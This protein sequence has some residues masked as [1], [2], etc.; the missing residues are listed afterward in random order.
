MK[1]SF[2][3]GLV[4]YQS[5][6]LSKS[7][8]SVYLLTTNKPMVYSVSYGNAE[9]LITEPTSQGQILAW[10]NTPTSG[11]SWLYI[12]INKNTAARTF[13]FTTVEP[14]ASAS[15]PF[16]P[17]SSIPVDQHWFDT[18]AKKMKV[19]DGVRWTEYIRVF[20]GKITN[21]TVISPFPTGSQV[22]IVGEFVSGKLLFD[23]F[24]KVLKKADKTFFTSEDKWFVDA[25]NVQAG[26]LENDIT[27]ALANES[28]PEFHVVKYT[29]FGRV[30]LADYVDTE[31]CAM[32]MAMESGTYDEIVSVVFQGSIT[33]PNWNWP[34]VNA[35]LWVGTGGT[36]VLE[37]PHTNNALLPPQVPVA[38][39]VSPTTVIF[40]QGL[41]GVGPEGPRGPAGADVGP[42]TQ[43][44]LGFVKI[45][46]DATDPENPIAVE[47][48]DP[49]LY[50]SRFPL[51]HSHTA[52][53]ISTTA[54]GL[55]SGSN[56]QVNLQELENRKF[57]TTGGTLSGPLYLSDT[58]VTPNQA[59]TKQYVD[60]IAVGLH[61]I[62]PVCAIN[63]ISD[64]QVSPPPVPSFGD[65]YIIPT[66]ALGEWTG[67]DYHA[68][69]WD[70]AAWEDMGVWQTELGSVNRRIGVSIDSPTIASGTFAGRDNSVAIWD[71]A[72][73]VWSFYIPVDSDAFYVCNDFSLYKHQQFIYDGVRDLWVVFG[74][75]QSLTPGNQLVL[76]GN[77]LDVVEGSGSDLDADMVDGLHASAFALVDHNHDALYV[78]VDGDT[79]TGPITFN[80]G[81][82]LIVSG[83][84][85]FQ[86][87]ITVSSGNINVQTG[88]VV[89]EHD[90]T[91]NLEVATKHYVD[92]QDQSVVDYANN[93]FALKTHTHNIP[94]DFNFFASGR[95]DSVDTTI[96]LVLSPREVVIPGDLSNSYA[97]AGVVPT[98]NT[99][100]KIDKNGTQV[101]TVVFV[102]GSHTGT[103]SSSTG[104]EVIQVLAGD[105][106]SI[107]TTNTID[108]TLADVAISIVGCS[109]A[110]NCSMLVPVISQFP[111]VTLSRT[112]D[113]QS[114]FVVP[115]PFRYFGGAVATDGTYTVVGTSGLA[116][117]AN[118]NEVSILNAT[119]GEVLH[120]LVDPNTLTDD[121]F[122][123]SVAINGNYVLVGAPRLSEG[124]YVASGKVYVYDT[125]TGILLRTLSNP[126]TYSTPAGDWFGYSV[127]VSGNYA[128]VSAYREQD[129]SGNA[130]SGVV[131]IYDI[132]SGTLLYTLNNPNAYGVGTADYFGQSVSISGNYVVVGAPFEEATTGEQSS[133][134]VYV[135]DVSTGN[136]LRTLNDSNAY[137]TP[138]NDLFG[139]S[140]SLSGNYVIVG[141]PG[142]ADAGGTASG[143][144]Y[145]IDVTSGSLLHTLSNPNPYG[146]STD[147]NFGKSVSISGNFAVVGA[148]YESAPGETNTGAAFLFDV[149]S[150]NLLHTLE[151][152]VGALE[153]PSGTF[154][155]TSVAVGGTK[156]VV[157][158]PEWTYYWGSES[159]SKAGRI[160][161]FSTSTGTEIFKKY[162]PR[163]VRTAS[164]DTFGAGVAIDGD[165]M[166]IGSPGA[167]SA[168]GPNSGKAFV[169]DRLTGSV[170]SVLDNPSTAM[171][172]FFGSS[173]DI[174]GTN[175]IVGAP[176]ENNSSGM[177]YIFNA[178]TGAIIHTLNN[179][180]AYGTPDGDQFGTS[181]S[182]SGNYAVVSAPSE[183]DAGGSTSGKVYI[184]NVSTGSLLF[185]LNNPNAYGT[186][187]GDMFGN[188]VSV[189]G[190][191]LVVGAPTEGDS[192]G[193]LQG[194]TYI[195]NV[196]TGTLLF[197]LDCPNPGATTNSKYFG[198]AVAVSGN[199]AV[200]TAP[201]DVSGAGI[202]YVY[203]VTTG[204]LLFTLNNPTVSG[205]TMFGLSAAVDGSYAVIGAP[206][207]TSGGTMSGRVQVFNVKTGSLVTTL[208]DPNAY[209][210]PDLDM[211]GSSVAISGSYAL[212]G[213]GN[214]N[215]PAAYSGGFLTQDGTYA[216]KAYVY[217]P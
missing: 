186:S 195:F 130:L 31:N 63:L 56:V 83:T 212:I 167:D 198:Y 80:S 52:T 171:D 187:A 6:V 30:A 183:G 153:Y 46:V 23:G 51:P 214:E 59:V 134:R 159:A 24:G 89:V 177:A 146:T 118:T 145:I 77:T 97:Y 178:T 163:T 164:G 197:T 82:S 8:A 66:G 11:D 207:E 68:V 48:N 57:N 194:K 93:T 169:V 176:A 208:N 1:L 90:P 18:A 204:V 94:Y 10:P 180:N 213:A 201:L 42:A 173:V 95:I 144:A 161:T 203:N 32:A 79:I 85:N 21:G 14:L 216:G 154:F 45:S 125:T 192:Y 139:W 65:M 16:P 108:A 92:I 84:T 119:T 152:S 47:T 170:I 50:D 133:G 73:H 100:L 182:I 70:G 200:V 168:Y 211:F 166:V 128:A 131:Y 190:N 36:L 114:T 67:L 54:Y 142:E 28:I 53:E 40:Q 60:S 41:G 99:T 165:Y 215:E 75:S 111:P 129:S 188:R 149:A 61:W 22:S 55:L 185:T 96:G 172:G 202:A 181:V 158:G 184:F 189:D 33:N 72:S 124:S 135:F 26:R 25:S 88:T 107:V 137:G 120:T 140:V 121:L 81:S 101:G 116:L 175:V 206:H 103:V 151:D 43:H 132:T 117:G 17:L 209:G 64:N 193:T 148:P 13:G 12:D 74:G 19:W 196:T 9:Y 143:K 58:P 104:D 155:G 44:S 4:Q 7:G 15:N 150:G 109:A 27:D 20:A 105:R 123:S 210:T 86:N 35:P 199:Y 115:E 106:L 156:V 147:D 162:G 2:R 136:L 91:T 34:E 112:I 179:P 76:N 62:D 191:Y 49:R 141:A 113:N 69:R 87:G 157:A 126:N 71:A 102:S 5:N 205:G 110:P 3:Q 78:N 138:L 174:N 127:S 160:V 122:G 39:V 37:D 38:R 29:D 217:G 98:S